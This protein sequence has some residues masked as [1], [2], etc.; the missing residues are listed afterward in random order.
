MSNQYEV[1]DCS[2]TESR[3]K[4]VQTAQV[5][6]T[7]ETTPPLKHDPITRANDHGVISRYGLS[8]SKQ[9]PKCA[10]S[11]STTL[12]TDHQTETK[13]I[14]LK[15]NGLADAWKC[16]E[17]SS[18]WDSTSKGSDEYVMDLASEGSES[19]S[20]E[21]EQ[22]PPVILPTRPRLSS[23]TLNLKSKP[24]QKRKPAPPKTIFP[25]KKLE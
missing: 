24:I 23:I 16:T 21:D 25:V 14:D 19:S 13:L 6:Q 12:T 7:S 22:R 10:V 3:I 1:I 9:L 15:T 4:P 2:T 11:S 8:S 18:N 20:D 17:R 5:D